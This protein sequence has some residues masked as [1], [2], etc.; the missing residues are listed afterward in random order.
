MLLGPLHEAGLA[1]RGNAVIDT[2]RLSRRT[3][4]APNY[5]LASVAGALGIRVNGAHRAM[6]DV[7]ACASI[8]KECI[9]RLGETPTLADLERAS[10]TRLEFGSGE[11]T[12]GPLSGRLAPI[13]EAIRSGSP[14]EI[15]YR[16][17][18]HGE[19]PRTITPLFLLEMDG[20][21]CVAALCHIDSALKNFRVGLIARAGE[22]GG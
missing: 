7:E 8:L 5:Q 11:P 13:T 15:V 18:S 1:P 17:G 16:G 12:F 3:I 14:L 20:A 4:K 21:L 10:A 6:P 9:A 19:S 22:P 2:C